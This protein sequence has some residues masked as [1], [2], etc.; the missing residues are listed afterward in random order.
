VFQKLVYDLMNLLK[1][2][3]RPKFTRAA[4]PWQNTGYVYEWLDLS[5]YWKNP[6]HSSACTL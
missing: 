4:P 3:A 2:V 1:K 5:S 6:A